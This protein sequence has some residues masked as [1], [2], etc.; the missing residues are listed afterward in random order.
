M[1]LRSSTGAPT[2]RFALP[3]FSFL[4]VGFSA[5]WNSTTPTTNRPSPAATASAAGPRP[6]P[7]GRAAGADCR[8]AARCRCRPHRGLRHPLGPHPP[9]GWRGGVGR[10]AFCR[11]C[12]GA[13]SRDLGGRQ[14]VRRV[15]SAPRGGD[16]SPRAAGPVRPRRRGG[17]PGP[18]RLRQGR[19]GLLQPSRLRWRRGAAG[20]GRPG[21][22]GG[23]HR[24]LGLL[25]RRQLRR[26]RRGSC[27]CRRPGDVAR[28]HRM[29]VRRRRTPRSSRAPSA[30]LNAVADGSCHR[31]RQAPSRTHHQPGEVAARW[32]FTA[33]PRQQSLD[34]P[35]LAARARLVRWF[36]LIRAGDSGVAV[37]FLPKMVH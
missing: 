13:H 33:V 19:V 4:G 25:V 16:R 18:T 11:P 7:S 24:R 29:C 1:P 22:G 9:R 37:A 17:R 14:L 15:T 10:A 2:I 32:Q 23:A 34:R 26:G 36:G 8:R 31:A 21:E 20:R 30:P 5:S 35:F 12:S 27:L 6:F 28:V 3:G